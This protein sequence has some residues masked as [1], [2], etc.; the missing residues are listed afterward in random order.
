MVEN[1]FVNNLFGLTSSLLN[2]ATY[3]TSLWSR[4]ER[5]IK[6]RSKDVNKLVAS[7]YSGDFGNMLKFRGYT[8]VL[9]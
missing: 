7:H 1:I 3:I 5:L 2:M 6:S 8:S 9:Q 4:K